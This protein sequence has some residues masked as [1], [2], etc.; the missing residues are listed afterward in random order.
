[1]KKIVILFI[2]ILYS[3][4]VAADLSISTVQQNNAETHL[5]TTIESMENV[6]QFRQYTTTFITEKWRADSPYRF[7]YGVQKV[8]VTFSNYFLAN[9]SATVVH[10]VGHSQAVASFGGISSLEIGDYENL[11]IWELYAQ[12]LLTTDRAYTS[13][14]GNFTDKESAM[15]AGAGMNANS[16]YSRSIYRESLLK[17]S[18]TFTDSVDYHVNRFQVWAYFLSNLN[19]GDPEGDPNTYVDKLNEQGVDTS[20]NDIFIL[21]TV[22][23][24][25]SGGF[26]QSHSS[27]N[28][29]KPSFKLLKGKKLFLPEHYVYHNSNNVSYAIEGVMRL[30]SKSSLIYGLEKSVIGESQPVE[31][32]VGMDRNDDLL[33]RSVL[34]T[35]SGSLHYFFTGRLAFQSFKHGHPFFEVVYGDSETLAQQRLW[36]FEKGAIMAGVK[37]PL[38]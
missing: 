13:Y 34:M 22:S 15:I 33:R 11:S 19:G 23:A 17:D 7:T 6:R 1:M 4:N 30:N 24:L 5:P 18:V 38:N 12:G 36:S 35:V 20:V 3:L 29:L 26:H 16:D 32:L 2:G 25:L 14:Y 10:E 28:E 31:F 9:V 8:L 27:K 37:I 21:H